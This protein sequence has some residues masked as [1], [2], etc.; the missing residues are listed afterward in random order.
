MDLCPNSR[1]SLGFFHSSCSV[2]MRTALTLSL[3]TISLCT[4]PP[5]RPRLGPHPAPTVVPELVLGPL[6]EYIGPHMVT[7]DWFE[8]LSRLVS[9]GTMNRLIDSV[10][11]NTVSEEETR[12]YIH[13]LS[14]VIDRIGT[15]FVPSHDV[16]KIFTKY[17]FL[18]DWGVHMSMMASVPFNLGLDNGDIPN[19][20]LGLELLSLYES[21]LKVVEPK[22]AYRPLPDLLMDLWGKGRKKIDDSDD[23]D[24]FLPTST[25]TSTPHFSSVME[26]PQIPS[27]TEETQIVDYHFDEMFQIATPSHYGG[28]VSP[29]LSSRIGTPEITY[30]TPY[31]RPPVTLRPRKLFS[32]EYE[33]AYMHWHEPGICSV[34][35]HLMGG[36]VPMG[37]VH[38]LTDVV[39]ESPDSGLALLTHI[40]DVIR[41]LF[42]Q[43]SGSLCEK[44]ELIVRK[45][46]RAILAIEDGKKILSLV[47]PTLQFAKKCMHSLSFDT[48]SRIVPQLLQRAMPDIAYGA[49][50]ARTILVPQ[51]GDLPGT[52]NLVSERILR[53]AHLTD[54]AEL[55]VELEE[56]E[57]RG[58]G[59]LVALVAKAV[60]DAV[61]ELFEPSDDRQVLIKPK[62][63]DGEKFRMFGRL[64]GI[65]ILHAVPVR[66]P[67]TKGALAILVQADL[68]TIPCMAWLQL[69]DPQKHT[70]L[71]NLLASGAE[72]LDGET[73]EALVDRVSREAVIDSVIEPMTRVLRG[74]YDVIPFGEL[75]WLQTEELEKILAGQAGPIDAEAL[76]NH[77][78]YKN[79][80]QE[81]QWFWH[82]VAT[83]LNANQIGSLLEFATGVRFAPFSREQWMQVIVSGPGMDRLPEAQL[84]FRQLRLSR[85]SSREALKVKLMCAIGECA[86]IDNV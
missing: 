47:A 63:E 25:R 48:R 15:S 14:A 36:R 83:D 49:P 32:D 51:L 73:V 52:F 57:A 20:R 31:L 79:Q 9:S 38:A 71:K 72:D 2:P 69:E 24:A 33:E 60:Q 80:T 59:P 75:S 34:C 18:N 3:L 42:T 21:F 55:R 27:E 61:P 28:F 11:F 6:E 78:D 54:F 29:P 7:G 8:V 84:C 68:D 58:L 77:T 44:A 46:H 16:E 45:S 35:S 67:L 13:I 86:T 74:V 5:K 12:K 53:N 37:A 4:T 40:N 10:G 62:A 56:S 41:I 85:Y 22:D 50:V 66:L 76:K 43:I 82:I 19:Q 30:P 26:P 81:I 39:L 17:P 70:G 64:L 1:V 65:V 23:D